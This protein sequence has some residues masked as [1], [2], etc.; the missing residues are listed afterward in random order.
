MNA[1]ARSFSLQ[2]HGV[3]FACRILSRSRRTGSAWSA[4][5]LD[6]QR[7][8]PQRKLLESELS[9]EGTADGYISPARVLIESVEDFGR[10]IDLPGFLV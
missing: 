7:R 10:Q 5:K 6:I 4:W 9:R 2:R 8:L 1:L 3:L